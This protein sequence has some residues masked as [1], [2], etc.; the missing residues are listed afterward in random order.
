MKGRN[1][2]G[3][4][5]ALWWLM[6]LIRQKLEMYYT[7]GLFGSTDLNEAKLLTT[8]VRPNNRTGSGGNSLVQVSID[9]LMNAP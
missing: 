6:V 5:F 3:Q 1:R 7:T 2:T 9:E 8:Y 4:C